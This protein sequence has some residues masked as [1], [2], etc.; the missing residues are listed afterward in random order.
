MK[1]AVIT[2]FHDPD[3]PYIGRCLESVRKQTYG[4]LVHVLVGDGCTADGLPLSQ[5]TYCISL[6]QRTNNYGDT[7]RS[8]GV[9]YAFSIGV[10]AVLFLDSDNWYADNHVESMVHK[11]QST[12]SDVVTCRR[13]LSHLDGSSL[14]VCRESD[15]VIFCDTNCLLI[16]KNLA[17]EAGVWWLIPDDL[18]AIDDR[19]IWDTLVHAT[20][21][22]SST[23][24]ATVYYRTAF[25]F[26]YRMFD[27]IP[28]DGCKTGSEIG[29]L[30]GVIDGLQARAKQCAERRRRF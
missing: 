23:G 9:V 6:P 20:D 3:S 18:H 15:G 19:V 14:G 11:C 5:N 27:R 21:N 13:Y 7:P 28:P 24:M 12:A 2:P 4:D 29:A 30:G 22:I 25:E 17:E 26:H 16:T 10:D 1:V 8:I